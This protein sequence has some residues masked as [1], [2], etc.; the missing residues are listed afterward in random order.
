MTEERALVPAGIVTLPVPMEDAIKAWK[1]YLSLCDA[2]LDAS[3][4]QRIGKRKFRK[5]SGWRKLARAFNITDEIVEKDILRDE[6]GRVLSAEVLVKAIAP[7]GRVAYGWGACSIHDKAHEEDKEDQWG[8]LCKGPCDGRKHFSHPDHDIPSTA[9][10]RAKN[11]AFADLIGAGEIS[12]EEIEAE[13]GEQTNARQVKTKRKAKPAREK[14]KATP[15]QDPNEV[16]QGEK[17]DKAWGWLAAIIE[18]RAIDGDFV[19][20]VESWLQHGDLTRG[21]F[22][23]AGERF[24]AWE[25]PPPE[26]E[27][28]EIAW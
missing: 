12:A 21:R 19:R 26:G 27:Q 5:R 22:V 18:E 8:N 11:R 4:Y 16:L 7:N 6:E 15:A 2:L 20:E 1:E 3:D 13:Q 17:L 14:A 23:E 25:P 10:T 28:D 9:H 24:K